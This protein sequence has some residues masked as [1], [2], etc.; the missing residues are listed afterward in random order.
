MSVVQKITA[1]FL[2]ILT[3]SISLYILFSTLN[4]K[5]TDTVLTVESTTTPAPSPTPNPLFT[6]FLM[7]RGGGGHDGGTLTDTMSIIALNTHTQRSVYLS[8]PRDLWVTIPTLG[9]TG[10]MGK[11]NSAYA[12]G[13]D[14]KYDTQKLPQYQGA[15]G[16]A[17]LS[18]DTLTRITG[19]TPDIH[20]IID[21]DGFINAIDTLGGVTLT[22]E[23]TFTDY[24]Y[25]IRGREK[26]D[27]TNT[28]PDTTESLQDLITQGKL[29]P[30]LLPK[31][32][33]EFPCRYTLAHFEKGEQTMDGA[34]A[35]MYVRSRHSIEEAGD[36][37]RSRRQR[38]LL[39]A[40][41]KKMLT[42]A[43]LPKLPVFF[44]KLRS[45]VELRGDF[46]D[47]G[48]LFSLAVA[49]KNYTMTAIT[50]S[51]QNFLKEG[52]GQQRQYI[53][54]TLYRD[55]DYSLLREHILYGLGLLP[56]ITH[57]SIILTGKSAPIVRMDQIVQILN[58]KE[59]PAKRGQFQGAASTS[60][61]IQTTIT[62][63]PET[64]SAIE[65]VLSEYKL[66]WVTNA[67]TQGD[68][69]ISIVLP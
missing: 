62:L 32:P 30:N 64:K 14:P 41:T 49:A 46:S 13:L 40:L 50:P 39:T 31:L 44:S 34:R 12:I 47:L 38:N 68:V 10:I 66:E 28:P 60:A 58:A 53:L 56:T 7:G 36:F 33:K 48:K 26:H 29:D 5:K 27:C 16:G 65:Q 6:V 57:P 35:L 25:P 67:H 19:L 4:P 8:L 61:K 24:E 20:V 42:P 3:I 21:F 18:A 59:F 45:N 51:T 63:D 17:R 43:T 54:S 22:V 1:G 15:S 23:R 2:L 9:D 55:E 52:Y 11:L 37:S 69:D